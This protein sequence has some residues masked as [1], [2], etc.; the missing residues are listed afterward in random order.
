MTTITLSF[1]L[2]LQ[3]TLSLKVVSY[4]EKEIKGGNTLQI[5]I[6]T[7]ISAK[8]DL[9]N[10][11]YWICGEKLILYYLQDGQGFVLWDMSTVWDNF[12]FPLSNHHSLCLQKLTF[13]LFILLGIAISLT[14]IAI[15]L[16]GIAGTIT[17]RTV[18]SLQR[19]LSE[20]TEKAIKKTALTQIQEQLESLSGVVLQNQRALDLLTTR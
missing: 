12:S 20:E 1:P 9:S 4:R 11:I 7:C 2:C 5:L 8:I 3:Q 15:S 10:G 13:P 17:D 6:Q 18:L 14:G 16:T 19:E